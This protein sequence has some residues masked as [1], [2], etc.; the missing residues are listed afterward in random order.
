MVQLCS[1][2][3]FASAVKKMH[4]L[5]PERTRI[6]MKHKPF[7]PQP[8][9]FL[10]CTD[11]PITLTYTITPEEPDMERLY[12]FLD[13][14]AARMVRSSDETMHEDIG[15]DVDTLIAEEQQQSSKSRRRRRK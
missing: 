1:L 5:S 8:Y 4:E 9:M 2:E 13:E 10:K 14:I 7:V 6:T 15:F 12:T 11:G 3:T